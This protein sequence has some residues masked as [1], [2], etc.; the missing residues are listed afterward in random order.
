MAKPRNESDM[1]PLEVE[2][3]SSER[4][5]MESPWALAVAQT[6]IQNSLGENFQKNKPLEFEKLQ[7]GIAMNL[8]I[9]R[10]K[11]ELITHLRAAL[12]WETASLP[13]NPAVQAFMELEREKN[14]AYINPLG[15]T[16]YSE[17]F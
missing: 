13:D 15:T 17:L 4:I 5:K 9:A 1:T 12:S 8:V 10:S 6:I 16:K 3:V 2:K 11:S 14:P 7:N